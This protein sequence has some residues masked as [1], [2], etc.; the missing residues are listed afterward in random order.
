MFFSLCLSL[1]EFGICWAEVWTIFFSSQIADVGDYE[2][3]SDAIE[4]SFQWRAIDVVVCNA[5]WARVGYIDEIPIKDL[6]ATIN[7]NLSGMVNTL[8]VALRLMK[9]RTDQGHARPPMSV[10]LVGSLAGLV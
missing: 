4:Q 1:L 8:H 2:T 3:L 10:V 7:T 5:G 6:H 9:H